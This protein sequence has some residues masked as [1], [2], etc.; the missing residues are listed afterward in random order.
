MKKFT[1]KFYF[2]ISLIVG[3]FFIFG[4]YNGFFSGLDNFINDS[5][6]TLKPR[7][8]EILIIGLDNEALQKYGQWPWSRETLALAL[9]KINENPPKVLAMDLMLAE[10]SR[11]GE[12]DDKKLSEVLNKINYPVVLVTEA[13]KVFLQKENK[14]DYLLKPLEIFQNSAQVSLGHAN[15]ILDSDKV[16]RLYPTRI[17]SDEVLGKTEIRSLAYETTKRSGLPI[18]REDSL[19]LQERIFYFGPAQSTRSISFTRIFEEEADFWQDKIVFLGV[20]AMDLH[21]YQITPFSKEQPM[22]GVEIQVNIAASLLSGIR[23]VILPKIFN[24]FLI[25]LAVF[26]VSFFFFK[27]KKIIWP[28]LFSAGL[29]IAVYFLAMILFDFGFILPISNLIFAIIFSAT[30]LFVYRFLIV[31]KEKRQLR[32]TFSR[33]VSNEVVNEIM[34]N[35]EAIALGG[36]E[37]EVTVFFFRYSRVYYDFRGYE[38]SKIG[39][40][41]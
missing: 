1:N 22:F 11:L 28:V 19:G 31:E 34:K 3:L 37:R 8:Q 4:V 27:F 9:Q 5:F 32:H 25:L 20:T 12:E 41:A 30:A 21:D 24:I 33:Y 14:V 17:Y 16:V 2:A 36:E 7:S 40:Y 23:L 35:P 13:N 29:I 18:E 10:N 15:I 39:S 26:L 6:F 38:F